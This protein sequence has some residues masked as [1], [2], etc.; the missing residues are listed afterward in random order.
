M[1]GLAG[2]V[3]VVTGAAGGIGA[4]T[5]RRLA[6]EGAHVVAVD[7]DEDRVEQLVK[8]LP[9]EGVAVRADVSA[10]DGVFS[11]AEAAVERFGRID[12][13]TSTPASPDRS[14]RCRP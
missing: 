13:T 8:S 9:T 3:A 10:E 5:A 1:R 12:C 6:D 2:K 7:L 11:Y 14:P 4:A